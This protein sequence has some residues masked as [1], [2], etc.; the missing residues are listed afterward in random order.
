[1]ETDNANQ[2]CCTFEPKKAVAPSTLC[3]SCRKKGKLVKPIT[4][5]SL[6]N[7]EAR[8]RVGHSKGFRFCPEPTCAVAYFHPGTGA[9]FLRED[10]RVRIGQKEESSP[11]PLCYC[12]DHAV[13]DVEADV[14]ATG[15]SPIPD[16]IVAKCRVGLEP[17]RLGSRAR[18]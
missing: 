9:Q 5:E 14:A 8:A 1:M 2:D 17:R 4:I 12:F 6:V 7:E 10:V 11:R 3:P 16:S 15:S 18:I 13:E